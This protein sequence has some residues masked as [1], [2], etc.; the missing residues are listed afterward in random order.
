MLQDRQSRKLCSHEQPGHAVL[1]EP[2]AGLLAELAGKQGSSTRHATE[3]LTIQ[4]VCLE[5]TN[6][7]LHLGPGQSYSICLQAQLR[8]SPR[9][10]GIR[11]EG[12]CVA[13]HV[14]A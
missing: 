1:T 3:E 12:S 7:F 11:P 4:G 2:Q 5:V 6:S 8:S 10:A 9:H 14:P 13:A